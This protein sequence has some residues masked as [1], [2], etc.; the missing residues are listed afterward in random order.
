MIKDYHN[1]K[2]SKYLKNQIKEDSKDR[3][4]TLKLMRKVYGEKSV[5]LRP[6]WHHAVFHLESVMKFLGPTWVYSTKLDENHHQRLKK[7]IKGVNCWEI[8]RDALLH[9]CFFV[10]FFV[11]N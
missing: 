6:K 7:I 1:L 2:K 11:S 8:S 4:E 5:H 9:V 10:F 3:V